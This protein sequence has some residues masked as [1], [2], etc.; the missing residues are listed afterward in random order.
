MTHPVTTFIPFGLLALAIC[1]VWL[2][3]IQFGKRFIYPWIALFCAAIITGVIF[4]VVTW[5]AVVGLGIFALC[6]YLAAHSEAH[7][8]RRIVFTTLTV[9][10]ALAL[11][12]HAL[13]GFNNPLLI[14]NIKFSADAIAFTQ[15]ANFDKAAAGLILLALLCRRAGDTADWKKLGRRAL[16]IAA[17]TT[18]L[19]MV[20]A[21]SLGYVK[22]DLKLTWY[23][24]LFL[25]VNLLFTCVAEEVF[26]RGVLQERLAGLLPSSTM[27]AII[28]VLCSAALFGVAH[29]GGGI[30]YVSLAT[31]SGIGYAY[32][33]HATKRV[34]AA[35]LVHFIV[36]AVHFIGF[37]YPALQ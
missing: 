17:I 9:L 6:A 3:P 5:L 36:N 8:L 10:L 30:I 26:F 16:P 20:T 14:E 29:I 24:P 34:E 15:K 23:T 37:T 33:Y 12:L 7:R 19:V 1:A 28:V 35:I 21:I 22:P 32:A 25:I 2:N 13:P 4:D 27:A 31:L 11:A 18:V